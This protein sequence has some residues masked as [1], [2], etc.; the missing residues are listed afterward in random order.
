MIDNTKKKDIIVLDK[1]TEGNNLEVYKAYEKCL[2][3]ELIIETFIQGFIIDIAH[4]LILVVGNI[5][6]N[7]QKLLQNIKNLLRPEQYLYVIHNLIEYHS[8]EQVN[9]IINKTN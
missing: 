7:E 9:T 2:R 3:D 5:N 1:T 8:R 6:L 4:I